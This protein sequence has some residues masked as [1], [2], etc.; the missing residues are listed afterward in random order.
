M[1]NFLANAA[2]ILFPLFAPLLYLVARPAIG[3]ALILLLGELLLPAN[4]QI[5]LPMLPPLDKMNG[6]CFAAIVG[7]LVFARRHLRGSRPF[8]G[9]DG[10]VLLM[11]IGALCTSLTNQDER[12][13]AKVLGKVVTLR[14]EKP[15]DA[16]SASI[17]ILLS[18]WVPFYLGRALFRETEDFVRFWRLLVGAALIYTFPILIELRLSPQFSNWFYG[19]SP[20]SWL[21]VLRS[22]GYRPMVFFNHGLALA[23]FLMVSVLMAMALARTRRG[24]LG[25]PSWPVYGVLLVVLLLC[26]SAGALL[27][28]VFGSLLL[29]IVSPRRIVK[30]CA[31]GGILVML[32]PLFRIYEWLPL[33]QAVDA[34][35]KYLSP[36]R[37]E[38]LAYRFNNES[39]LLQHARERLTFG[40]GG[41]GRNFIYDAETGRA[42]TVVDGHV[43]AL[44]GSRGLFGFAATLLLYLSP[45]WLLARRFKHL[46]ER[47][48]RIFYAHV[49]LVATIFSF[50]LI[51]N[52]TVV[53]YLLLML[54]AVVGTSGAFARRPA[55][56]PGHDLDELQTYARP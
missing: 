23:F 47:G 42:N 15:Y 34:A 7:A 14:G 39:A 22:G 29:A 18:T 32:Y 13:I 55:Q 53:P 33:Q 50:D 26:K 44:L 37:A 19:Y 6:P 31:I 27:Y 30:L 54:G 3:A 38:S 2:L 17:R 36:E 20:S 43:I 35:A 51:I 10:L 41:F 12:V 52:A 1:P 8:R 49:I 11:M 21:Q 24:V 5:D 25:L 46:T 48:E 4:H 16:L 56:Q 28:A 45:V 40:W 9:A